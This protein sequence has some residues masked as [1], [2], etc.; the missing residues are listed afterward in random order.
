MHQV[1]CAPDRDD[2]VDFEQLRFGPA[3]DSPVLD[4]ASPLPAPSSDALGLIRTSVADV[5]SM[6]D[7]DLNAMLES[8]RQ[9]SDTAR[10]QRSRAIGL[11]DRLSEVESQLEWSRRRIEEL[12]AE[13][14]R[15]TTERML[16]ESRASS[17]DAERTQTLLRLA[18]FH[19]VRT[20]LSMA[21]MLLEDLMPQ[22]FRVRE[23]QD[24]LSRV[25]ADPLP[26]HAGP[27]TRVTS[28]PPGLL[29]RV[30]DSSSQSDMGVVLAFSRRPAAPAPEAPDSSET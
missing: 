17:A 16:M 6:S 28:V 27:R 1:G 5:R 26:V 21:T 22:D 29:P 4:F 3:E 9:V 7:E 15:A 14:E 24:L 25:G 8:H 19:E 23:F 13:K 30:P 11:E 10:Q 2:E 20:A 12:T 18:D